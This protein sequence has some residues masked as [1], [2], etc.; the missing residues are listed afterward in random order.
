MQLPIIEVDDALRE[1]EEIRIRTQKQARDLHFVI[2]GDVQMYNA[3]L[4]MKCYAPGD[5]CVLVRG[6]TGT[7]KEPTAH[8]LH[9]LKY[10]HSPKEPFFVVNC[11]GMNS[12]VVES[13]LF[14]HV[15]SAFT[16]AL[17]DRKGAFDQIAAGGTLLLDEVG[18]MPGDQQAKLLRALE[19][20]KFKPVGSNN[21]TT[22][23][24]RV[25]CAT[26]RDLEE[27]I[28]KGTF[29]RDLFERISA[30]QIFLPKLEHRDVEHRM[31]LIEYLVSQQKT[32]NG[33]PRI[34][35]K[36]IN[37]LLDM[38][39]PGNVRGLRN[40]IERS[41][42][43]AMQGHTSG[44]VS[45]DVQHITGAVD[46]LFAPR[47]ETRAS[48]H[49]LFNVSSAENFADFCH[50]RVQVATTRNELGVEQILFSAP[51]PLLDT[52]EAQKLDSD[53][54]VQVLEVALALQLER[55]Y[56]NNQSQIAEAMTITRGKVRNLRALS[57][58]LRMPN[59]FPDAQP[60]AVVDEQA[61]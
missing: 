26:N 36:A 14:G 52:P 61:E 53:T 50:G 47:S 18:D 60:P 43:Y 15:K 46:T 33:I 11:A 32:P 20:K 31:A 1:Q 48:A 25:V 58:V 44:P 19:D 9:K 51:I 13:E 54:L 6:E 21:D 38:S 29:R 56:G 41:V 37:A 12:G 34:T 8:V 57:K 55:I 27:M 45:I 16:G 24:G 42:L 10:E 17:T 2:D 35:K 49:S 39:F 40:H 22:Y 28:K 30:A 3:F 7:G 4:R 59:P 23:K 5:N